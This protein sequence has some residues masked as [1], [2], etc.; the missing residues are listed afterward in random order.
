IKKKKCHGS[1]KDQRFRR[2]CRAKDMKSRKIEK[3]LLRRKLIH[4]KKK[5]PADN[6]MKNTMKFNNKPGHENV[7]STEINSMRNLTKRKRDISVQEIKLNTGISKST[8]SI[9]VVQ[10]KLKMLQ[11]RTNLN[12]PTTTTITNN[13]AYKY[14]RSTTNVFETFTNDTYSNVD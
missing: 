11:R 8:S 13:T 1:R 4:Y 3:L 6:E 2:K 12:I 14:Y 7:P 9:S 5:N 10:P